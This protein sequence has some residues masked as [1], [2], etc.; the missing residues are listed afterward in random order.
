M[1]TTSV[2]ASGVIT[3]S[4]S[5]IGM[6]AALRPLALC[7][8]H[9]GAMLIRRRLRQPND[10]V[11]EIVTFADGTSGRVYRQTRVLAPPSVEPVFLVVRFRLRLARG[12]WSHALF[13]AE[14]ILNTVFFGGFKGLVSKL[15]LAHDQK[16]RYR[17][18]YEWDGAEAA[19]A[20]V[21]AL[22]WVLSLVSV[23]GSVSFVIARGLGCEEALATSSL[24]RSAAVDDDG[25]WRPVAISADPGAE[26]RSVLPPA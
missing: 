19:L 9:T 5:R 13:R 7:A 26:P 24:L 23:P 3:G 8:L 12:G 1:T 6:A 14:S 16:G 18:L 21:D 15:W 2:P 20:Y 11:G 10:H 4:R 17:G 25:W 22:W